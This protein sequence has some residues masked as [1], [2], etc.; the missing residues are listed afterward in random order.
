V[1]FDGHSSSLGIR[2]AEVGDRVRVVPAH[3][4]PTMAMHAV[5]WLVR[6]QEV[7]DRWPIDLRGW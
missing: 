2:V 6:G 5:A 4:D 7:L 1:D 3:I